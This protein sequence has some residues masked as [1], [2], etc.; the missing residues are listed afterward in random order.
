MTQTRTPRLPGRALRA[1]AALATALVALPLTATATTAA[2]GSSAPH[3]GRVTVGVQTS[4]RSASDARG[5]YSYEL[6]PDGIASDW[7]AVTNYSRRPVRVRLTA[8]DATTTTSDAYAVQPT[9]QKAREVGSWIALA[10]TRLRLP[11]RSTT[12]VPFRVGVPP[13]ARPGDHP[14]AIVLSLLADR[15]SPSAK[16]V[17]VEHRVGLRVDVRVPGALEPRLTVTGLTSHYRGGWSPFGRGDVDVS[18]TLRNEGNVILGATDQQVVLDRPVGLPDVEVA[19]PDSVAILP[20]GSVRVTQ[21]VPGFLG[22]GP[23][24]TRV[25]LTPQSLDTS[26]PDGVPGLRAERG[27][28]AVPWVLVIALVVLLASLSARAVLRRRSSRKQPPS[29]PGPRVLVPAQGGALDDVAVGSLPGQRRRQVRL[30]GRRPGAHRLGRTGR[31]LAGVVVLLGPGLGL[32]LATTPASAADTPQWQAS[33]DARNGT[34]DRPLS[35]TTSGGC[36]APATNVVGTIHGSGFPRDGW[37][38]VGNTSAGVSPVAPIQQALYANL[39][40]AMREQERPQDLRGT[41]RIVLSCIEPENDGSFGDYVVALRFTDPHHWVQAAPV[42]RAQGPTAEGAN[43]SPGVDA[44]QERQG[45]GPSA[46]PGSGAS[47]EAS[48][49]P[50]E[51][52][53]SGAGDKAGGSG[54]TS[55]AAGQ[56]AQ[57]TG[58]DQAEGSSTESHLPLW[59]IALAVLVLG[60]AGAVT[61]R[62]RSQQ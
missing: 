30:P 48:S 23:V 50:G 53:T 43:P 13:T 34:D 38:V 36:P 10:R 16:S 20:G 1:V 40:D 37:I 49:G 32:G 46:R 55:D 4:T 54:S 31:A 59:A 28:W 6:E 39:A 8:R 33:V 22:T 52:T 44:A 47:A 29:D 27:L 51:E 62:R 7:I 35:V 15:S 26:F 18:Y 14:G 58:A 25:S 9:S 19:V 21:T 61:V 42:T 24:D 41:Y 60:A 12:R 57:L 3:A 5:T 2:E 45:S 56:A 11:A 17:V